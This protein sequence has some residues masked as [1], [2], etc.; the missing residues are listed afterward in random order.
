[1]KIIERI[2]MKRLKQLVLFSASFCGLHN[3][4]MKQNKQKHQKLRNSGFYPAGNDSLGLTNKRESNQG[5][6]EFFLSLVKVF[7][8]LMRVQPL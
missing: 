6:V 5:R 8:Q 1:M 7:V 4:A 2:K 3:K